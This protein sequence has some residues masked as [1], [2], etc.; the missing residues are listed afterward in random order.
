VRGGRILGSVAWLASASLAASACGEEQNVCGDARDKI[1]ACYAQT[2]SGGTFAD[3]Q[4][5]FTLGND[6][7]T[8]EDAC[9]STCFLQ[10]TCDEI[11]R[12][13]SRD[14]DPNRVPS[15]EEVNH[16]RCVRDCWGTP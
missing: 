7:C 16:S 5:L 6:S 8:S 10:M 3:R 14:T 13:F 11:H 2:G 12:V 1:E 4:P 9:A 15:T